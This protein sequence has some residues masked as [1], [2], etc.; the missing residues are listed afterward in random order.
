MKLIITNFITTLDWPIRGFQ[1]NDNI[2]I[3]ETIP[4]M[5]DSICDVMTWYHYSPLRTNWP[6]LALV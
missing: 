3:Y 5:N 2:I 6:S 1:I 4:L